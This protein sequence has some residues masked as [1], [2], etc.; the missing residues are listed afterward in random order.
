MTQAVFLYS[1]TIDGGEIDAKTAQ[2]LTA[3]DSLSLSRLMDELDTFEIVVSTAEGKEL[4]MLSYPESVCLAPFI[5]EGSLRIVCATVASVNVFRGK[6]HAQDTTKVSFE[7]TLEYDESLLKVF[8][9]GS[10]VKGFLPLEDNFYCLCLFRLLDYSL[11]IINQTHLNRYEFEVDIDDDS[12]VFFD[13]DLTEGDFFYT[14]EALF[15]EDFT[16]CKM[17]SKIHGG[18]KQFPIDMEQSDCERFLEL[19]NHYR[20]FEDEDPIENCEIIA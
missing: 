16:Q 18:D 17:C 8:N 11:P 15:N 4:D 1:I 10:G 12:S 9:S 3:R 2:K 20:I 13:L 5:D 7:V 14:A 19:I 6:T